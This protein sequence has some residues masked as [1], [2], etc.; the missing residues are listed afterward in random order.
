MLS[1]LML[2]IAQHCA[3]FFLAFT[4]RYCGLL[5]AMSLWMARMVALSLVATGTKPSDLRSK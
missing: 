5:S 4:A 1:Q 2:D 3:G